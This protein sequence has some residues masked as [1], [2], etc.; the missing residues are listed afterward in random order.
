[1]EYYDRELFYRV[2]KMIREV[3]IWVVIRREVGDVVL[4]LD[5]LDGDVIVG[6]SQGKRQ[7]Q[8]QEPRWT[9]DDRTWWTQ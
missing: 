5:R 9:H 1:M 6:R 4:V 2:V 7:S 8:D 3:D